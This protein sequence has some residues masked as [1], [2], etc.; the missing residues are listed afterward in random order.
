MRATDTAVAVDQIACTP[1]SGDNTKLQ[2]VV[3]QDKLENF[4]HLNQLDHDVSC[5]TSFDVPC[6]EIAVTV[7]Q[8]FRQPDLSISGQWVSATPDASCGA[9]TANAHTLP[10]SQYDANI[11]IPVKG[12]EQIYRGAVQVFRD[13]DAVDPFMK[14]AADG[15]DHATGEDSAYETTLQ[16][17]AGDAPGASAGMRFAIKFDADDTVDQLYTF[18][19]DFLSKCPQQTWSEECASGSALSGGTGITV[20]AGKSM[21]FFVRLAEDTNPC[22]DVF[23]GKPAKFGAEDLKFSIERQG[24]YTKHEYFL[25]L[26]CDKD[27]GS[28]VKP[29][30]LRVVQNGAEKSVG[31]IL[32]PEVVMGDLLR[33]NDLHMGGR[34]PESQAGEVTVSTQSTFPANAGDVIY[35]EDGSSTKVIDDGAAPSPVTFKIVPTQ[36]GISCSYMVVELE[37]DVQTGISESVTFRVQC[38]RMSSA[39]ANVEDALKLISVLMP[40]SSASTNLPSRYPLTMPPP[41]PDLRSR[42]PARTLR[43]AL[44]PPLMTSAVFPPPR[45]PS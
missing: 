15:S 12:R 22:A 1:K 19:S 9:E 33:F 13:K 11:V 31:A 20:K 30:V 21:V 42:S 44:F 25:P 27:D 26:T 29:S 18:K 40:S 8:E 32:F 7:T 28:T 39:S 43:A 35:F 37:A 34:V 3:T 23:Q 24:S 6:P 5:T 4:D 17:G 38:P 14:I 45:E 16:Q 2:C 41:S 36:G 10:L